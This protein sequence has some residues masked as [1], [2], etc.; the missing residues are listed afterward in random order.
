MARWPERIT[1]KDSCSEGMQRWIKTSQFALSTGASGQPISL[2]K[3]KLSQ[4]L[5]VLE[6]S[7]GLPSNVWGL[8]SFA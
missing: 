4:I 8:I 3:I 2:S 5:S 7:P 6:K 1:S